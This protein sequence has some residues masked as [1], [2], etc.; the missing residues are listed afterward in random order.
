MTENR[1]V[2]WQQEN[3]GFL[4]NRTSN[5]P[6]VSTIRLTAAEED[7]VWRRPSCHNAPPP[8]DNRLQTQTCGQ[9]RACLQ[10]ICWVFCVQACLHISMS[11]RRCIFPWLPVFILSPPSVLL[12]PLFSPLPDALFSFNK[13]TH[14]QQRILHQL[15]RHRF[16]C[17]FSQRTWW[18]PSSSSP[19]LSASAWTAWTCQSCTTTPTAST[20]SIWPRLTTLPSHLP[21]PSPPCRPLS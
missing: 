21:P 11:A 17:V 18:T 20:W 5:S 15:R 14:G 13:A 3:I 16:I 2:S 9:L 10:R 7:A 4:W 8:P 6:T 1:Q 12:P 19:G